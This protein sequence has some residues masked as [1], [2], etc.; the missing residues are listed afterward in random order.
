MGIQ[1]YHLELPHIM[2]IHLIFH[3]F[4]LKLCKGSNYPNKQPSPNIVG[5]NKGKCEV[6][7]ILDSYCYREYVQYL[8]KWKD[9]SNCD[10]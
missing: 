4:L 9:Y 8:I 7:E 5:N 2:R 3:V 1:M 10:N 6:E